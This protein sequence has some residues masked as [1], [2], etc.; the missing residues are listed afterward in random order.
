MRAHTDNNLPFWISVAAA[1]SAT[2]AIVFFALFNEGN[3]LEFN[4]T[5]CF[6][7]YSMREDVISAGALSNAA[8]NYGGAGYVLEYG[9]NYYVT[10]ACYYS[11][12]DAKR[13][14]Q[15]LL[16]RGFDCEVL[17]VETDEYPLKSAARKNEKLFAGNLNTLY[18]LSKLCYDCANGLDTG[19]YSQTAAKSVLA[20]VKSG[21]N[22]LKNANGD[23]CFSEEIRRLL[24]E[25]NSADESYLYSKDM[26]KLQIAI[27][28]TIINIKL[29]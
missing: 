24:A 27:A 14:R 8:S 3:I 11:E 4:A 25:C 1:L 12:N 17:I 22:G 6:V 26:R 28:D 2:V 9:G 10:I 20:D 23:N 7:C 15:S 29:F 19:E 18:S 5:F 16:R 21:L 13:I